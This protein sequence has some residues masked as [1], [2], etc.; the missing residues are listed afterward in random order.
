VSPLRLAALVAFLLAIL[1]PVVSPAFGTSCVPLVEWNDVTY[2]GGMNLARAPMLG[3]SIGIGAIP[4]CGEETGCTGPDRRKVT[5]IEL[6]DIPPEVAIAVADVSRAV[7]A[8][9]GYLAILPGEPLHDIVFG[10]RPGAPNQR[11]GFRCD[12]PFRL[13]GTVEV[14]PVWGTNFRARVTRASGSARGRVGQ[15]LNLF[16]DRRT[17]IVG[18]R[19]N[20]I[21]YL[22]EGERVSVDGALCRGSGEAFLFAVDRLSPGRLG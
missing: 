4:P 22:E 11:R 3:R 9:P 18:L 10:D 1:A 8:A 14:T 2:D 16:V 17:E 15:T 7:Y 5:I 20:G 21:P 19:R 13:E 6:V 12:E